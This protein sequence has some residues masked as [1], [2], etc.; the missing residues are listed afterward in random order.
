MRL[1]QKL[2]AYA[3]R[4][5]SLSNCSECFQP[6]QCRLRICYCFCHCRFHLLI[7]NR[8]SLLWPILSSLLVVVNWR[9][10]HYWNGRT[11]W[12]MC[13]AHGIIYLGNYNWFLFR[14]WLEFFLK[15][16][17]MLDIVTVEIF[18]GKPILRETYK[19]VLKDN[20]IK[21]RNMR[22]LIKENSKAESL[23]ECTN[24]A[25]LVFFG[26]KKVVSPGSGYVN[27]SYSVQC[28]LWT[29]FIRSFIAIFL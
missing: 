28:W 13:H 9:K 24:D 25:F 1:S 3:H 18:L 14:I 4:C 8:V 11:S 2:R 7:N 5:K 17:P 22:Y 19:F 27:N 16:L 6:W 29:L 12:F 23:W 20:L 26:R 10:L 21:W 15:I